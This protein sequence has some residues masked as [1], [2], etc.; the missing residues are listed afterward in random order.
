MTG[1]QR[2]RKKVS[3]QTGNGVASPPRPREAEAK[4]RVFRA[5]PIIDLSTHPE[6]Y[7][8]P[9]ELARYW[10]V[11]TDTIYRDIKKGALP[12]YRIGSSGTIR[13]RLEDARRYGRPEV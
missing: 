10:R 11:S 4:E 12:A 8:S 9:S 2:S 3:R 1:R 6:R 13:I 5:R 7:L